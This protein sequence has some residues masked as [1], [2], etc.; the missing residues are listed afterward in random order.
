MKNFISFF[1][2]LI[3]FLSFAQKRKLPVDTIVTTNHITIIKGEKLNYQAQ[4]GTQPVMMMEILLLV[5]STLIIKEQILKV[6]VNVL[7]FFLL[8]VDLD[9]HQ[10]G[11]I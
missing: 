5:Y 7:L 8:T 10:F 2:L 9:Q 4:T 6:V 1:C 3:S 11:C